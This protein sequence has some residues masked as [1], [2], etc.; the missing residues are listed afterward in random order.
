MLPV[1]LPLVAH[2]HQGSLEVEDRT[3]GMSGGSNIAFKS[4]PW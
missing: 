1:L 4:I 2:M 3:L